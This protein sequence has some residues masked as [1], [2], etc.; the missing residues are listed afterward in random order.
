MEDGSLIAAGD[1]H[2]MFYIFSTVD[3]VLAYFSQLSSNL[4]NIIWNKKGASHHFLTSG[5]DG[6]LIVFSFFFP[7]I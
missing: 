6:V 5:D 1:F 4:S 3:G 2:N 7:F